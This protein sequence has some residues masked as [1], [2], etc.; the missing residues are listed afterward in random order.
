MASVCR[1][2]KS[3]PTSISTMACGRMAARS[4]RT[5]SRVSIHRRAI[6]TAKLYKSFI[7]EGLTQP[8]VTSYS[9]ED[10]QNLFKQGKVANVITAPVPVQPDQ[11]RSA[12]PEIWC[13]AHSGRPDRRQGHLWRHRLDRP[14]REL[15]EQ[16]SSLEVPRFPVHHGATH[17]VRQGRRLPAGQCG[18]VEGSLFCRQCRS[19]G[20]HVPAAQCPFRA[21]YSG[22][23]G[24]RADDLQ[25]H[26][27]DL[28]RARA[29]LRRR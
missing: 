8:G 13:R 24:H 18:R 15:Q 14:V 10:V 19:E 12:E 7:D 17:Q 27:E 26:P 2:R 5:A 4:S 3:R 29:S 22:L 16:G 25:R 1:A 6:D 21:G 20:L 23:G 11:G 9:R 28:S